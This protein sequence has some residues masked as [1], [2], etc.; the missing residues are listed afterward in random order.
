MNIRY[1]IEI[2]HGHNYVSQDDRYRAENAIDE[3]LAAEGITTTAEFAA[4]LD[5][6]IARSE[7]EPC[8][9]ALADKYDRI[10]SAGDIALTFG[11]VHTDDAGL[12]LGVHRS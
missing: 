11:W 7:C 10:R 8:N 5:A 4:C 1:T 9:D 3:A 2:T 6:F 12:S